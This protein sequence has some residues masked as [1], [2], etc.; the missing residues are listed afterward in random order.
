[1]CGVHLYLR[2][3]RRWCNSVWSDQRTTICPTK[4][5]TQHAQMVIMSGQLYKSKKYIQLMIRSDQRTTICPVQ[6][7]TEICTHTSWCGKIYKLDIYVQLIMYEKY[8]LE[9]Y[10]LWFGQTNEAPFVQRNSIH[11]HAHRITMSGQSD[12]YHLSWYTKV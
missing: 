9:I 4:L 3:Q 1:M 2:S 10:N 6:L 12:P 8:K 5:N 11:K 7:N